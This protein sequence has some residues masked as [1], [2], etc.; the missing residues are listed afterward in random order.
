MDIIWSLVIVG[1]TS[2]VYLSAVYAWK[3]RFSFDASP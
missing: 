1:L 3:A 2:L